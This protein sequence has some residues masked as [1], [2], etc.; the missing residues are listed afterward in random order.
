[1]SLNR[2]SFVQTSLAAACGVV[3]GPA[4]GWSAAAIRRALSF[5][6]TEQEVLD[7]TQPYASQVRL[8]GRGVLE[9]LRGH[10]P[11]SAHFLVSVSDPATLQTALSGQIP[12]T[13]A[14]SSG[15]TLSGVSGGTELILENVLP[16]VFASRTV[17]LARAASNVFGYDGLTYNPATQQVI[18]P[19]GAA[20]ASTAN[21]VNPTLHGPA[22]LDAAIRGIVDRQ[23]LGMAPHAGLSRWQVRT[24]AAPTPASAAQITAG[25]F[26]QQLASLADSLPI[27][28]TVAVLKS[29]AVASALKQVFGTNAASVATQF[30]HL[31]PAFGSTTSNAALWLALLLGPEL[32]SNLADG[33]AMTWVQGGT[34]FQVLRSRAAVFGAQAVLADPAFPKG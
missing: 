3:A 31:R 33:A 19:F 1:M 23:I 20:T 26:F 6:A 21:L 22:A 27:S 7:F 13:N 29:K 4:V 11:K 32:E 17:A 12:F 10:A 30:Q 25:I 16:E 8:I 34:R 15:N 5:G 9:K 2:R 18:D 24:L 28:T 14:F